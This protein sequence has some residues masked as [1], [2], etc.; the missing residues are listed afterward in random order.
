MFLIYYLIQVRS[1]AYD[2]VLNGSEIGGGSI[3]IHDAVLQEYILELLGIDKNGLVHMLEMLKSGCPSHGGIALG[4]DRLFAIMLNAASIREV[5]AF[6]KT[7][8][9]KDLLSGAPATIS[10]NDK[11]L[12]HIQIIDNGK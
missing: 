12:Y 8:D 6:P 11:K 9:G 1:L 7:L 2:L 10:E 5:I 4:L 3:R